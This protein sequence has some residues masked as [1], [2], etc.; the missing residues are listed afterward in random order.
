MVFHKVRQVLVRDFGDKPCI[1]GEIIIIRHKHLNF[2]GIQ[3]IVNRVRQM[4]HLIVSRLI[5]TL[6]TWDLVLLRVG[7]MITTNY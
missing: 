1:S 2:I 4:K 6:I 7:Q 5:L 3:Q